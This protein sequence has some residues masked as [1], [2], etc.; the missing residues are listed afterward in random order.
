MIQEVELRFPVFPMALGRLLLLWASLVIVVGTSYLIRQAAS[1]D[2]IEAMRWVS[3]T[4]EVRATLFELTT[5]LNETQAAALASALGNRTATI[6]KRYADA[7]SRY[8]EI[9]DSLRD[10]TRDSA[11]QQERIGMLR[12]RIEDRLAVFDRALD[13]QAS[14]VL[15]A[16][17]LE[18]A[19]AR[20]PV[21]DILLGVLARE[22]GLEQARQDLAGRRIRQGRWVALGTALAQILL[23]GMVI[24]GSERQLR[25]RLAAEATARQAVERAQLIVATVREPIA[26]ISRGSQ[27]SCRQP[28]LHRLLRMR[29]GGAGS[30]GGESG[31]ETIQVLLQRLRDVSLTR[32]E[33]L[34]L[35]ACTQTGADDSTDVHVVV[36]ARPMMLPDARG[37]GR[38]ADGQ[39]HHR[40]QAVRGADPRAQPPAGRQGRADLREQSRARG[41]LLFGLARSA[42]AAAA[43]RGVRREAAQPSRRRRRTSRR[44]ITARSSPTR[45]GACPSLIEDLLTLFAPRPAR[46]A[47]AGVDMQALVDE[48]RIALTSSVEDRRI[49]WRIAPLP[50]VV[51]DENMIRLVWQNLIDNAMKYT[52]SREEAVI[53]IGMNE[54]TPLEWIFWVKRQ[55][56]RLRHGV[57]RQ[58]VRR[59]PAPAQGVAVRRHRHR[60]RLG[61][62]H[63][64][65][66]RRPHL[67]RIRAGPGLDLLFFP[68]AQSESRLDEDMP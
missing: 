46:D 41:V 36:N 18:A 28:G 33:A 58:A 25:R 54:P 8:G 27:P 62:A 52:A 43:Y 4:Q 29:S 21:D 12:G 60:P 56:R 67:G 26:V 9:L 40:A 66:A 32:R 61:A 64:R 13:E 20:F 19:A 45:R 68:A 5:S 65:P 59:V 57:R 10:L 48:V 51:A 50:V 14:P 1:E 34:G 6:S 11:E 39:R 2:T 22:Q 55:R 15:A 7:K 3:H 63:R 37:R 23:L 24:W 35:R 38:P 30:L 31:V 16:T 47:A 44:G 49:A 53:E 17:E 42:R